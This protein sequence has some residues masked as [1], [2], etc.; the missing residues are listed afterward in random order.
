MLFQNIAKRFHCLIH[1]QRKEYKLCIRIKFGNRLDSGPGRGSLLMPAPVELP[2]RPGPP[3]P[4]VRPE[5][6]RVGRREAA[7]GEAGQTA[8]YLHLLCGQIQAAPV[9]TC[10][11]LMQ[12]AATIRAAAGHMHL[13]GRS[14]K[15]EVNPG[16]P[17][18]DRPEIPVWDFDNQGP[19]PWAGQAR[20]RGTVRVT[21]RHDQ[22][23]AQRPSV[24]QGPEE[25][26]VWG[27]G[28]TDEMCLGILLVTRPDGQVISNHNWRTPRT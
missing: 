24:V 25:Q 15:L 12:R 16:T 19:R 23:A 11:H 28:A 2:C 13:L 18:A 6:R 27:E 10:D 9:Q 20:R 1:R 14:I 4:A 8:N 21:C 7:S 3:V 26:F 5:D 22:C 17:G